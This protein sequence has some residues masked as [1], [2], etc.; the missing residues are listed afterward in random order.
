MRL[1]LMLIVL[2]MLVLTVVPL[3]NAS[4]TLEWGN[5]VP[6]YALDAAGTTVAYMKDISILMGIDENG[7]FPQTHTEIDRDRNSA[8]AVHQ[9]LFT[10]HVA[11]LSFRY[12][13]QH[14]LDCDCPTN[15]GCYG[16]LTFLE[17]VSGK[18]DQIQGRL[19]LIKSQTLST[20]VYD[21]KK[22]LDDVVSTLRRA[23][24]DNPCDKHYFDEMEKLKRVNGR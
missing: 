21:A 9:M 1:C 12:L 22:H 20:Q 24:R 6:K 3:G 4:E 18:R 19:R 2:T 15:D 5:D 7:A 16:L 8:G 11:L 10:A 14:M 23:I 13:S 17:Y